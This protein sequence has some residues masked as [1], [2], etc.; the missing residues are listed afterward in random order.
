MERTKGNSMTTYM[1]KITGR[2]LSE[3]LYQLGNIIS[4]PML[5]F[6][7]AWIYPAYDILMSGSYNIQQWSKNKTPWEETICE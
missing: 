3:I 1:K 6:D 5:W 7:W 4:Y 2:I